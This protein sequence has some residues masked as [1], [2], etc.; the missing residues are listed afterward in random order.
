V[1]GDVDAAVQAQP[2]TGALQLSLVVAAHPAD[3]QQ[4]G[5]H[6]PA[7]GRE[8][9]EQEEQPLLGPQFAIVDPENWTTR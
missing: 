3:D 2:D 5:R 7:D 4:P 8:H 1:A 6:L 9:L